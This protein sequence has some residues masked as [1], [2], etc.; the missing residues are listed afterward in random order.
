MYTVVPF[1][2]TEE[3]EPLPGVSD[4][5]GRPVCHANSGGWRSAFFVVAV[6]VAS[7]FASYGVSANLIMYMTGPLGHSNA[8]AAAAM[9]VWSGTGSLMPLLGAFV[10]D[11]WLG[12]Y[13][14]IILGCTLY[15]LG[16]GMITLTSMLPS[17][18]GDNV[19][20]SSRPL[21]LKV[22]LFYTSL[23]TLAF[24]HGANS[25][26]GLAF[27]ADQFDPDHPKEC[28]ARG[29]LFNWWYF[30]IAIGIAVAIA[31]VSYT[32]ENFG[33]A[34]GFGVPC[35]IMICAF[36]VFL[37]GTP[38]Y[39]LG[40][41]IPGAKSP[42]VRL[43]RSLAIVLATKRHHQELQEVD[44]DAKTS[45]EAQGVL[46]LLPI[47]AACL[48][49]GVV[50]AQIMTL[51]NKQ[52]RTLDRRVFG[53]GMELPPA[54][55]QTFGPVAILVFVP[56]YDRVLVPALR[57]ATGNPS[58]LT[59]LQR[60]GTGMAVSLAAMCVAA[61]VE[62]RRLETAREHGLVD[63]ASATVPMSWAWMVPQYVMIGVAD[64]F[65]VVGMQEFFYDQMPDELRSLGLALFS[66]V[67]G[68]G[69]FISGALIYL[70]DG[71]S[72]SD[73]G[74]SWFA[75]NLNRAHLDY[76]YWLLAGLSAAELA[77][78]LY[79][80]RSYVYNHKTLR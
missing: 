49:Y 41:P 19:D 11:S 52:S 80:A 3:E 18:P 51:F 32:Q 56:I 42:F 12:R 20:F 74:D 68:I 8:A 13:R 24:A 27:A 60:V 37:L 21:S 79:L 66:G 7:T 73:G 5:R 75:D 9:N 2:P 17:L 45:E 1:L 26:C 53:A 57:S 10:A 15:V 40:V 43:A 44:E 78:Y 25:P 31:T 62:A 65:A 6:E 64:V 71:V 59:L 48:A 39:R 63:D 67:M 35:A 77:L 69:S 61:L 72:S 70:I 28:T 58:G 22:A 76:F 29:S 30:S 54:A 46:R 33:W 36:T 16:Y 23:Y 38:T 50:F 14:S 4:F 34:I 55:L 47:W